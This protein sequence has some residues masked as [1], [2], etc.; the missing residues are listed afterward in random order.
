MGGR[1]VLTSHDVSDLLRDIQDNMP[2]REPLIITSREQW[3]PNPDTSPS[4][5]PLPQ[6]VRQRPHI[7]LGDASEHLPMYGAEPWWLAPN[8]SLNNHKI[9]RSPSW[10]TS[11]GTDNHLHLRQPHGVHD[12]VVAKPPKRSKRVRAEDLWDRDEEER[13]QHAERLASSNTPTG[14]VESRSDHMV[15][16]TLARPQRSGKISWYRDGLRYQDSMEQPEPDVCGEANALSR[17]EHLDRFGPLAAESDPGLKRPR[18][19]YLPGSDAQDGAEN[20]PRKRRRTSNN[21]GCIEASDMS[22]IFPPR[23]TIQDADLIDMLPKE[24]KN[25]KTKSKA[26]EEELESLKQHRGVVEEKSVG[27]G[28]CRRRKRAGMR[29]REKDQAKQAYEA[30]LFV[31]S[32]S[33]ISEA[34]VVDRL[35]TFTKFGNLP[36]NVQDLIFTMVLKSN[37]PVKLNT[38][39]LKAFVH[40]VTNVP[41]A[42]TTGTRAPRKKHVLKP[43]YVLHLELEKMEDKLRNIM[44]SQCSPNPLVSGLALSLLYVSKAVHRRAARIFY[45]NNRFEFSNTS[46]AWLHLESFLITIG[47]RNAGNIQHLSVTMPKWYP[48]ASEDRIAGALLDVLSPITRLAKFTNAD[49]DRLLSA[50]STCTS[51]LTPHGGLKSL[52]IDML[53]REMQS[54]LK[55]HHDDSMYILSA[56]EQKDH[57]KRKDDGVRLL[58]ALSDAL[59]PGC[60]PELVLHAGHVGNKRQTKFNIHFASI[61]REAEKYGWDVDRRLRQDDKLTMHE[62]ERFA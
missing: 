15:M 1:P 46:D 23:Q 5:R 61:V 36:D 62:H 55:Y 59:S 45:N 52:Q 31:D 37:V 35:A 24:L 19:C 28:R 21:V 17:L 22:G 58:R 3:P 27:S 44:P 30:T 38:A 8:N 32:M 48:N 42:T 56:N 40:N 29:Q 49:D 54:F 53:F 50:I 25:E 4:A 33:V 11:K 10:S 34:D 18:D 60:K 39:Q 9:E 12:R 51:I 47:S 6:G 7:R 43:A 2:S 20:E 13:Q 16:S 57:A 26:V 14:M 41:L